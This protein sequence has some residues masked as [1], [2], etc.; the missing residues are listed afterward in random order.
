MRGILL[1]AYYE[2]FA[3]FFFAT[4]FFATFLAFFF[5]AIFLCAVLSFINESQNL[6]ANYLSTTMFD[7]MCKLFHHTSRTIIGSSFV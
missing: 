7:L 5:A 3:V 2:R 4:F 1:K 6:Y